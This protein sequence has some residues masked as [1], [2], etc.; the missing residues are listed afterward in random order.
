MAR[1]KISILAAVVLCVGVKAALADSL[2]VNTA[3][4]PKGAFV[5]ATALGVTFT[6]N[7]DV[8]W[9]QIASVAIDH[10]VI[11]STKSMILP[12]GTDVATIAGPV[13]ILASG[14][15][16]KISNGTTTLT[17]PLA[18]LRAIEPDSPWIF[19]ISPKATLTSS[20]QTQRT[21]GGNLIFQLTQHP[22]GPALQYRVTYLNL[23]ANSSFSAK[24]GASPIHTHR[25]DGQFNERLYLR[26]HLYLAPSAEA[27]HNSSLNLYLQQS[28]G[29][30]IYDSFV[31][32]GPARFGAGIDV[33]YFAEHF[34]GAVP[35]ASFPGAMPR[36]DFSVRLATIKGLPV[37]LA[38]TA[39]YMHPFQM[40]KA[41]QTNG[42]VDL[43]VPF[44]SAS[45]FTVSWIDD[46]LEN[47]PNARKNYSTTVVGI[48]LAFAGSR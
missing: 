5:T 42:R 24:P 13:T 21:I 23:D 7:T 25:Y 43:S 3:Q 38:E 29:G 30:G 44:T 36:E 41:W 12:G 6:N 28:Y 33:R 20:T 19:Q 4:P 26:R 2:S 1:L 46:Y 8:P 17:V 32:D 31:N 10:A 15:S 40:S 11:V 45:K 47:A 34:Y 35:G 16:L 18:E 27:Y 22:E 39:R 9:A 37:M 48:S 14:G